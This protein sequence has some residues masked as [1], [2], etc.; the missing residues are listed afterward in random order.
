MT[1][2]KPSPA[3]STGEELVYAPALL[4]LSQDLYPRKLEVIREYI[5]NASDALEAFAAIADRVDDHAELQ[6]KVS[7]QGRSLLVF[8]NGIGM[9]AEE[10]AKLRRVAYSE[11]KVGQEAGY[12]GIGRLAGI[13]VA[14]KLKISST[15]YGD[16]KLHHFEFRAKDMRE[17]VDEKKRSGQQE[18][19]TAV[20]N[21]HTSITSVEIDPK[22]HYTIVEVRGITESCDE[23]LDDKVLREYIGEIAPVEF[24]PEFSWGARISQKLRQN[25]PDYAP[26]VIYL[27]TTDGERVRIFKPFRDDMTISEPDFIE[28]TDK[29]NPNRLLA[30]CWY[31]TKG[32]RILSRIRPAG[33]IFSTD[34]NDTRERQRFAGLAYK[35]F[36]FS[37]GD[38]T[39]PLR[40]LWTKSSPRALW[41]TGEVHVVDKGVLPTTDRSDFVENESRRRLYDA[42]DCVPA[43]LN[44]LA[45]EISDNRRAF[46]DSEKLRESFRKWREK[47]QKRQI[48]RAQLNTVEQELVEGIEQLKKRMHRCSDKEIEEFSREI[49]KYGRSLGAELEQAKSARGEN[50]IQDIASELGLSDKAKKVFQ[51]VME[52]LSRHYDVRREEYYEVANK[53]NKALRKSY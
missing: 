51:I 23:L 46:S 16:P 27:S 13:A 47:L 30:Y 41:F 5:Q 34:G 24:S 35:L 25:V 43:K 19:A 48:E 17:D 20:I 2:V 26:K 11:K 12:K 53:I 29:A 40:S 52:A 42:A 44:R 7:V 10:I 21:R 45:Q 37:I 14:E 8:D 50:G 6:I 49:I 18:P 3:P 22:D 38:R 31:A 32:Q 9:D 33:K 39:L 15:S 28:I 4:I 36:G 1:P